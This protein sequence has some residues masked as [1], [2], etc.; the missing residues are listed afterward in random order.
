MAALSN[1]SKP[2]PA[3]DIALIACEEMF[4]ELENL[5]LPPSLRRIQ[6]GS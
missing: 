1:L 3:A 5:T 4:E 2:F 6:K